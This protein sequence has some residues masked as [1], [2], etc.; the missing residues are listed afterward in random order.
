[1]RTIFKLFIFEI[2]EYQL[3]LDLLYNS[4]VAALRCKHSVD[5]KLLV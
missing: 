1:V 3:P 5:V 2:A 4:R